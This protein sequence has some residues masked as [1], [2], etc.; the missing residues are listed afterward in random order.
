VLENAQGKII[1]IDYFDENAERA[2]IAE[3]IEEF[4]VKINILH[5][6]IEFIKKKPVG[7]LYISLNGDPDNTRDALK[8]IR[9]N[10][11]KTEVIRDA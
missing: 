6:R 4:G 9:D 1:R 8:F 2:L 3:A 11:G 10:A 5:G 7:V